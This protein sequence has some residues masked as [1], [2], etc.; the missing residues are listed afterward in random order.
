MPRRVPVRPA[1]AV[2]NGT[3]PHPEPLTRRAD[4]PAVVARRARQRRARRL[5]LTFVTVV[6]TTLAVGATTALSA[7]IAGP[8][9]DHGVAL[10]HANSSVSVPVATALPVPQQRSATS[11]A[12]AEPAVVEGL[13]AAEPVRSALSD[14]SDADVIAAVGGAAAFRS[15]VIDGTAPCLDTADAARIWV[16]VNK[17]HPLDP[18]DYWPKPQAQAADVPRTSGGHMRADVAEALSRLVATARDE[19]AGAIGVNSGFRS[20][21]RQVSTYNG[22]VGSLGRARADLTSARPGHSEHQTGLAVDVVACSPGCRGIEAFGRTRQAEWVAEN[23]WRFGFVIR[24]EDG[25]TDVTGYE[26]EPWHLRYIGVDLAQAYHDG[27]FHS[28]EA[29]FGLEPAPAYAG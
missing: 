12:P 29:F 25:A 16:V 11:E 2:D 15:A 3:M 21:E 22:Y 10:N 28:L 19:G 27:G 14:G 4:A 24:Y 26:W 9:V 13:C 23:A 1:A 18:I 20:Y 5:R 17:R 8:V 6:G 7:A